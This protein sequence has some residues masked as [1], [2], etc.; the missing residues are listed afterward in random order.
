MTF[1]TFKKIA[2]S[3]RS[4]IIVSKHGEYCSNKSKNTL[5]IIF[6]K[7]GK[8]S[9]VYDY[10]GTYAEILNKL[11]IPTVTSTDYATA[12]AQL[13]YYKKY[14]GTSGFF[15]DEV[16]D[17]SKEIQEYEQKIAEYESDKFIRDWEV[18]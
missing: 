10:S 4:D 8:Q 12:K 14:H 16:F 3:H 17:F 5:G 13:D 1:E 15:S 2:E 6:V 11:D 18:K 7:N 9:K